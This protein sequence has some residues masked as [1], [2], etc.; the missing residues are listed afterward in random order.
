MYTQSD[1]TMAEPIKFK[2][3]FFSF[4]FQKI[5]YMVDLHRHMIPDL[6]NHGE[7]L[8]LFVIYFG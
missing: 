2:I 6:D 4:L 5:R 8:R 3:E 1:I 7:C